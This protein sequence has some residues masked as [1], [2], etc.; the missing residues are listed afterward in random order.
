MQEWEKGW[1]GGI[2]DGEGC[3]E[4]SRRSSRG[5]AL[6]QARI[7]IAN[8]NTVL[9]DKVKKLL[10]SISVGYQVYASKKQASYHKQGYHI[11][12]GK[13]ISVALLIAVVKPY[14]IGKALQMFWLEEFLKE[15]ELGSYHGYPK[16]CLEIY[17]IV[18]QMNRRSSKD[19][20]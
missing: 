5:Y 11:E 8:T 18:S 3:V 2:I 20:D 19:K 6:Y 4:I 1:L 14:V 16:R 15:K 9:I 12:V 10:D 13:Q 17:D 7:T